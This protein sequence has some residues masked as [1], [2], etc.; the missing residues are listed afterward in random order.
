V[1]SVDVAVVGAGPAGIAAALAAA[2]AGARTALI[3][4]QPTVGGSLRWRIAPIADLSGAYR[5]LSGLPGV[6]LAAALADRLSATQVEVTT[7]GVAWGWFEGNILGVLAAAEAYELQA[8]SIVIASGSTDRMAPFAGSM[9]PGVMTARAVLTFLHLHRVFPGRRFAVIGSGADAAE[10]VEA[11]AT[12]GAEVVA[13]ADG[14]DDLRVSGEGRVGQIEAAGATHA[15][16]CVVVALGRQPDPELAL[17]SLAD[18]VLLAEAGGFVPLRGGDCETSTPR[19]YVAGDA[20]GIV[21]DAE[22]FAEGHLAGLAAADAAEQQLAA[23]REALE[24][25]RNAERLATIER[26]RL[27]VAAR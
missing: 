27:K 7:S 13:R 5:D 19:L 20:A 6:K 22:A 2:S 9:F 26:L 11:I 8:G 25:L 14:L 12:A 15:V 23:A 18:N 16:D 24:A 1:K 3:D 4:E 21:S 17:Q 10:V